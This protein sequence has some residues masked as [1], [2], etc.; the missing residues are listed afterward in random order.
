M[1]EEKKAKK[2]YT[3]EEIKFSEKSKTMAMISCIPIIG[4]I[5]LF[6]EKKDLFVRYHAAQ[7][8]IFNVGYLI[9][10]IPVIGWI[11]T[12]IIGL[13]SL[14]AFILALIKINSGARYDVPVLSDWGLKLM[15][16]T[17]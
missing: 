6:V 1:A 10:F 14:I 15:S 16:A 7:F 13:I 8:A 5:M 17:E 11:I 2:I 3:L 12:P 4:L 9:G